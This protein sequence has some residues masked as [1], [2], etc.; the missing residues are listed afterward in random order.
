MCQQLP[1]GSRGRTAHLP[2]GAAGAVEE[3]ALREREGQAI[4]EPAHMDGWG[5][6]DR[7][8]HGQQLSS[9]AHHGP[10]VTR[11]LLDGGRHWGGR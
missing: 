6:P 2:E 5:P 11:S 10:R 4:L 3:G 9:P 8:H 1:A 7:A